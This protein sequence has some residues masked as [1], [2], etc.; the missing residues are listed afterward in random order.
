MTEF[1]T[2]GRNKV[3]RVPARGAY[4]R[5]TVYSLV[6]A[7]K[8]CHV[9]FVA[10]G[11]PFV[12]PTIHARMGDALV[13]HGAT[14]SRL[15]GHIRSGAPVCVAITLMD[16]LVIAR[17]AFHH[18][19]NYRSA[20]IF[21]TGRLLEDADEKLQALECI[22]NHV[23]PGRWDHC[24]QPNPTELKATSVAALTIE[25]ASAKIREGGPIDDEEDYALDVWAGVLPFTHA[26]S[27][28]VPDGR[29]AEGVDVPGHVARLLD[30]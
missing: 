9:G 28:I 19:M 4:D 29:L 21:G 22:T 3:R 16:G 14:K 20:V 11:Q 24:R 18:S 15:I 30:A 23:I 7:A 26:P 5:E 1:A 8:M 6:D 17:S 13:F 2:T 27:G 12:I 25:S 10:D